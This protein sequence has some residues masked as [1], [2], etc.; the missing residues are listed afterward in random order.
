MRADTGVVVA[1]GN[2]KGLTEAGMLCGLRGAATLGTTEE[3][4][5]KKS[6]STRNSSGRS[7]STTNLLN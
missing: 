7:N 1:K 3:E 6:S 4:L 2:P 5:F